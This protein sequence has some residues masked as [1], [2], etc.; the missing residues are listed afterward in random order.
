LG[1]PELSVYQDRRYPHFEVTEET[2]T[3]TR[4]S[5]ALSYRPQ[6]WIQVS[7]IGQVRRGNDHQGAQEGKVNDLEQR[8]ERLKR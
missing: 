1:I 2:R 7:A 3:R 8:L 4:P 6:R 5:Q